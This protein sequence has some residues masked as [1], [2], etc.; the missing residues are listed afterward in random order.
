V[1]FF[2]KPLVTLLVKIPF[3][4]NGHP[5]SGFST[6]SIGMVTKDASQTAEVKNA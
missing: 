2:T 6:R 5:L 1:F 3:F 4:N